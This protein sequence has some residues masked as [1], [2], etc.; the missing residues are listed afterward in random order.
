MEFIFI[1]NKLG[2]FYIRNY[3]IIIMMLYHHVYT[4]VS[5]IGQHRH[6]TSLKERYFI[7]HLII[8]H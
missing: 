7:I 8:Y 5:I 4:I 1:Q 3:Y 6:L 2:V